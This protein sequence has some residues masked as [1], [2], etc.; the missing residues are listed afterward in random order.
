MSEKAEQSSTPTRNARLLPWIAFAAIVLGYLLFVIRLHPTNF[1]GYSQ[2]DTLYFSSAKAIAD[3]QGYVLPS[4]PGTPAASKYP[5][6]YAWLLS[7]VWRWNSSFPANLSVATGLN[8]AFGVGYLAAAFVFLRRLPAIGD[9]GAV[10][11]TAICAMNPRVLFLS[12]NLMS[13][14]P[15]AALALSACVIASTTIEEKAGPRSTVLCGIVTGLSILTRA[16]GLPVAA[17]ICLGFL[18]RSGWRKAWAFAGCVFPFVGALF[19]R[20]AFWS[21]DP[22]GSTTS[23]C[24][25]SWQITRLYYTSYTGFWRAD[26]LSHGV[27]WQTAGSNLRS[28]LV[29]PGMYF[30]K[31]AYVYPA[32]LALV[33]LLAVTAIAIRGVFRL[34]DLAGWQPVHFALGFSLLPMLLWDY[35]IADR[36]MIPFLPLIEAAIWTEIRQIVSQVRHTPGSKSSKSERTVAAGF[37]AVSG[38]VLF[39]GV[40]V[41]WWGEVRALAKTS[42]SRGELL[43][44]KRAAYSWLKENTP[45]NSRIL[46]YEDASSFLYSGRQ[47]LRPVIFS[48]A[49]VYRPKLLDS[50]LACINS[51]AIPIGAAYWITSDDDFVSEWEPAS[52]RARDRQSGMERTYQMLFRS[53]HGGVRIYKLDLAGASAQ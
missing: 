40:G 35:S 39:C 26:V 34:A 37:L 24:A 16:M 45:A 27:F 49:G 51:N 15:F 1:F 8:L 50:E 12:A 3:G 52:S 53:D 5:I 46:A 2:D 42:E 13:D 22:T 33:L 7:W 20:S 28:V 11:L 31:T 21:P 17:G 32:V 44:E 41:S 18:L 19:W 25:Q 14:L 47:S 29:Q 4:V 36:F 43:Q 23:N 38:A 10:V 30:V 6:L 48:A 9:A